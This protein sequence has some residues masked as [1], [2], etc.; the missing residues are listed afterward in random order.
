MSK[1][2]VVLLSGGIDSATT[3]AIAGTEGYELYA[4]SINYG[5]RHLLEIECARKIAAFYNVK[6]HKIFNV[7]LRGIGGS[8]L[9]SDIEVP[10]DRDREDITHGIP[11]TYVPAR[12]TIFLAI[13]LSW[14]EV[15]GADTIFF[16]ANILDY[17]GYPDCRPEFIH[18]FEIMANLATRAGVEGENKFT[19]KTPLIAMTKAEIIKKGVELGVDFS[20]THSCYDPTKDGIACGRCDSCILRQRGFAEAGL[21]DPIKY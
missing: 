19:I 11:V 18:A 12:N 1:K 17:S 14:A 4:L 21:N 9:T 13:S 16:G 10:K 7:D 2:A 5:Q 20:M 6:E 3:L 8:A 15:I